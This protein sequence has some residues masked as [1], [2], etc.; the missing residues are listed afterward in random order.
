MKP[1]NTFYKQ[2][3]F[4]ATAAGMIALF[5]TAITIPVYSLNP[6]LPPG[7]NFTLSPFKLQT[8]NQSLAFF[9]M[10]SDSLV[11]GYTSKYFYTDT[12]DGSMV[13]FTPSNG[14]TTSGSQYPRNE[15]RQTSAG[16]NWKLTDTATHKMSASCKVTKA[17]NANPTVVIGQVHGSNDNSEL[18]ELEWMGNSAGNCRVS[19]MFQTN[20]AAGS[21]YFVQLASGL[22]LGSLVTYEL[23]MKSGVVTVTVNGKSG[24]QTYTTQ[25]YGTTDGYY[26]KA[27]NYLQY[28]STDAS[29]VSEVKF[30]SLDV[31]GAVPTSISHS[32]CNPL[33]HRSEPT[34]FLLN[35]TLHFKPGFFPDAVNIY[36]ADGRLFRRIT[37]KGFNLDPARATVQGAGLPAGMYFIKTSPAGFV[38]GRGF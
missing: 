22:S 32:P 23:K 24:S 3:N 10:A 25:Y 33:F 5:V 30:Y 15:L 12:T 36:G 37:P 6:K 14:G 27:G 34:V 8:L 9:E 4:P 16:A 35:G 38:S 1:G 31:L 19:A 13:F 21:N 17:P 7:K 18:I 2:K 20:D 29:A 11:N 28:H 26:F